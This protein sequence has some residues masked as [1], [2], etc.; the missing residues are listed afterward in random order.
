MGIIAKC[1]SVT[2]ALGSHAVDATSVQC[3]EDAAEPLRRACAR[4]AVYIRRT[5]T[6]TPRM[7]ACCMTTAPWIHDDFM[8]PD[9]GV[10]GR[11]VVRVAP[12]PFTPPIF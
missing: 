1:T 7:H 4:A 12:P 10:H 6:I 9:I 8:N 2:V 5:D 3:I 11:I